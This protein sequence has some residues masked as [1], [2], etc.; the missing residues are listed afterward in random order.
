MAK[1]KHCKNCG[2][3]FEIKGPASK[4]C[5]KCG[6][7]KKKESQKRGADKYRAK[8]QKMGVGSGN[9]QGRGKTHHSYKTGIGTFRW[10][11]QE[12]KEPFCER[13][14]CELDFSNSYKWCVHHKDHNRH[15]NE[16]E[17]LEL[18]CKRC[19]QLEHKCWENLPN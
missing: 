12:N 19:H 16:L 4:Y 13:C 14:K 6:E 9:N 10:L 18:L 15:N 11:A 7:V 2:I 1:I 5:S 8:F 17:N 3:E